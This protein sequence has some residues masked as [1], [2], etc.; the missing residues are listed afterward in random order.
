MASGS[1][2]VPQARGSGGDR[3]SRGLD[4]A[5][6]RERSF[7][8]GVLGKGHDGG[9]VLNSRVCLTVGVGQV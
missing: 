2:K 9:V 1:Y 5:G 4:W 3:T 7:L 8:V 6:E